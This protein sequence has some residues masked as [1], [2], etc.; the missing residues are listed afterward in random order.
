[1]KILFVTEQFPYPLD[2]GGNIRTFHVLKQLARKH[3]VVLATCERPGLS[4]SDL[5]RLRQYCSQVK[6][7]PAI[8]RKAL[9]QG[10]YLVE[11]LFG[12]KPYPV[13]RNYSK[14]MRQWIRQMVGEVDVIHFNHLDAA[15]YCEDLSGVFVFDTHNLISNIYQLMRE[16]ESNPLK[17][18][19]L[20]AQQAKTLR[21]ETGVIRRMALCLTCSEDEKAEIKKIAPGVRVESI[22]NGVD[23]SFYSPDTHRSFKPTDRKLI[24]VGSMDYFPNYDGIHFFC[25]K[26]FGIL[27]ERIPDIH[28]TLV[29]R[30]PPQSFKRFSHKNFTATGLVDDIRHNIRQ[31]DL[32]VVPIRIGGGTRIKVLE[33][34]AQGIPVLSTTVGA[35]GI[36]AVHKKDIFFADTSREMVDGIIQLLTNPSLRQNL[37]GNGREMVK[38]KYDW[39]KVGEKLLADYQSIH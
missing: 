34:M 2:S 4:A 6:I 25:E 20:G 9:R 13:N 7:F 22:P 17:R 1:M 24:F 33:G 38:K 37:A 18:W 21:Y 14:H 27:Q 32:M 30:K 8:S 29:G 10:Y 36:K 28:L 16:Q 35:E 15:C 23:T 5:D 26:V 19:F 11:S 31:A 39:D 12:E 3:T